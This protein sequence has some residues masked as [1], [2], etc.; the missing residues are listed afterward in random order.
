ML[1][2]AGVLDYE[3]SLAAFRRIARRCA[4]GD[5]AADDTELSQEHSRLRADADWLG[6]KVWNRRRNARLRASMDERIQ[7]YVAAAEPGTLVSLFTSAP[8]EA[9]T[10]PN[11]RWLRADGAR[12]GSPEVF[13]RGYHDRSSRERPAEVRMADTAH[14]PGT[15]AGSKTAFVRACRLEFGCGPRPACSCESGGREE[16]YASVPIGDKVLTR[17]RP[18]R[19]RRVQHENGCPGLWLT[20]RQTR[21]A[22]E[23][24]PREARSVTAGISPSIGRQP[25]GALRQGSRVVRPSWPRNGRSRTDQPLKADVPFANPLPPAEWVVHPR[26]ECLKATSRADDRL[27]R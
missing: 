18:P 2:D 24:V 17:R 16:W 26:G 27:S 12:R 3:R 6:L 19:P 7:R 5:A 15:V 22:D 25:R 20:A 8:R 10:R 1:A 21:L 11:A 23:S 9:E 4:L 14:G 13:T